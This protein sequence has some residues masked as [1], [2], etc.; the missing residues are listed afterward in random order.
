MRGRL[1]ALLLAG[2]TGLAGL[3]GRAQEASPL[4]GT[5]TA[6][7]AP[8]VPT[9]PEWG[10]EQSGLQL[11]LS[12]PQP[13]RVR[14]DCP[15]KLDLRQAGPQPAALAPPG[16]AFGWLFV[17]QA[18]NGNFYTAKVFCP[19]DL[20]G[21]EP[22]LALGAALSWEPLA[23]GQLDCY[24]YRQGLILHDGFPG[25]RAATTVP[26]PRA[27]KLNEIL[28]PGWAL[29]RWMLYLPRPDG[30][31]GLLL[32]SNSLSVYIH[33]PELDKMATQARSEYL[34]PLR[35]KY[36]RSAAAALDAN[37]WAVHL[38]P[39]IA[40]DLAAWA[41]EPDAPEYTQMWLANTLSDLGGAIAAQEL[42]LLL[43]RPSV[44][45]V[46]AYHGAKLKDPKLDEALVAL[47]RDGRNTEAALWAIRGFAAFRDDLPEAMKTAGLAAPAAQ[48]RTMTVAALSLHR[49]PANASK[50]QELLKSD[51]PV[52]RHA[53]TKALG[54]QPES[55]PEDSK[56]TENGK[57]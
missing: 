55:R 41:N 44:D 18:N 9:E 20:P 48:L 6:P 25:S 24:P 5:Q 37:Y 22:E 33:P 46:A 45:R 40:P 34:K 38:G 13:P 49:N 11:M 15:L 7:A 47:V 35:A 10:K 16:S 50:L 57:E 8:K 21:W 3:P 31:P 27:G 52:L 2:S 1:A 54:G 39:Q 17:A 56:R 42:L 36:L 28:H 53:A 4:P 51:D 43:A 12:F 30:Q 32:S 26:E 19:K 14:G 29:V 23:A